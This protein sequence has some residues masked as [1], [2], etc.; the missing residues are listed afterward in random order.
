M[1][2]WGW[3]HAFRS[4]EPH[5][6]ERRLRL[7]LLPVGAPHVVQTAYYWHVNSTRLKFNVTC[8]VAIK[9]IAFVDR[10]PYLL[11]IAPKE[12]HLGCTLRK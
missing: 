2:R 6:L 1:E 10:V 11:C 5:A 4:E 7:S 3:T 9:Q 12:A 8:R